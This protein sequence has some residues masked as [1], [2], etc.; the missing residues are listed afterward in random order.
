MS[1]FFDSPRPLVFAHRG[2]SALGPENTV[3]AF[4]RGIAAGADGIELDVHLSADGVVIVHHDATLDRTTDG[5]GPVRTRTAAELQRLDAACRF[6]AAQGFPLRGAGICVPT[7]AEVL[8]RYPDRRLI[9]EMKENTVAMGEAVAAVVR[10]TGAAD[11][12]CAAGFG[13]RAAWA[14]RRVLPE[15]AT[16]A[17]HT[18]VRLAL[19][20]SWLRWPVRHAPYGGYQVPEH[21][22]RI[23]V[24]SRRFIRHAHDGGLRVQ[25]WTVDHADDMRRLL[26]WGVDAL[27][28]DQ[29]D[30]AVRVV[31]EIGRSKETPVPPTF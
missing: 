31:G 14:A 22:G 3:A 18:E 20:R 9:I 6:G 7:L 2:G 26:G 30:V 11:R 19:Y 10:A 23:R 5:S 8:H 24:V 16:S 4:D 25:V 15:M 12:V 29:P 28:S 13:L 1:S 27:I 21:A 17:T